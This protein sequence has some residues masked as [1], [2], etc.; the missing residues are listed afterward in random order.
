MVVR[1]CS[2]EETEALGRS[3]GE[4]LFPGA[5]LMLDGE[6]GAGKSVF[7]RGVARA[8]QV[9]G[10]V[11]SP[12]FT[13]LNVYEGRWPFYHFDLYRLDDEGDLAEL[14][15][16]EYLDGEGVCAVEWASKFSW[17]STV[18]SLL[19][20]IEAADEHCREVTLVAGG[21]EYNPVLTAL[22]PEGGEAGAGAG[23]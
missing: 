8:L 7:A 12:T 11:R 5:V 6:L 3:V 4:R 22:R 19:I 10:A 13:L 1:T 23:D 20:R 14:G 2:E 18:P 17:L 16:E 21:P 15:I 9:G